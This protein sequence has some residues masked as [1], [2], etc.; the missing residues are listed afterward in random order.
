MAINLGDAEL[1]IKGD[2]SELEKGFAGMGK[3]IGVA[4]TA[5]GGTITAALGVAVSKANEFSEGIGNIAT[6]GVPNLNELKTGIMDVAQAIGVDLGDAAAA[7]Y[8]IISAGVE[9]AKAIE[10]LGASA[11]AAKAGI[12][13]LNDAVDLGTTIMNAFGMTTEDTGKI[14]DMTQAAINAGKTNIAE[15]GASVGK[16]APLMKGTGVASE[17]LFA[18]LA[19]LTTGGKSTAESVTGL[20]AIIQSLLKPTS[21]AQK[22][23]KKLGIEWDSQALASKGLSGIMTELAAATGGNVD[24]ISA[25]IP[26]VEALP[27]AL[28]LMADGG[29]ELA[30]KLDQVTNSTGE[31][32]DAFQ[33]YVDAN[34]AEK[35][36]RLKVVVEV[37]AIKIG[38]ALVPAIGALTDKLIPWLQGIGDWITA[39]PKLSAGIIKVTGALGILFFILG[40]VVILVAQLKIALLGVGTAS[41]PAA[42][43][44]TAV[45][46]AATVATA[47]VWAWVLALAA[48]GIALVKVAKSAWETQK[49]T[50]E[51][52]EKMRETNRLRQELLERAGKTEEEINA[53]SNAIADEKIERIKVELAAELGRAATTEEVMARMIAAGD[54][55]S[56]AEAAAMATN[57]AKTAAVVEGAKKEVAAGRVRIGELVMNGKT[58][59]MTISAE[60]QAAIDAEHEK[61]LAWKNSAG[62]FKATADIV[63]KT[64]AEISKTHEDVTAT[65]A[66]VWN[67]LSPKVRK[68]VAEIAGSSVEGTETIDQAWT[69]LTPELQKEFTQIIEGMMKTSP[70]ARQSPSLVEQT[71]SGLRTMGE[72]WGNFSTGLHNVLNGLLQK[73]KA[74]SPF[75]RQSPSIVDQTRMGTRFMYGIW[76]TYFGSI[77]QLTESFQRRQRM[78][79]LSVADD[80]GTATDIME[81]RWTVY[82][83]FLQKITDR[84]AENMQKVADMT[85]TA[86]GASGSSGSSGGSS[87]YGSGSSTYGGS[88][89]GMAEA[90]ASAT[91]GGNVNLNIDMSGASVRSDAD[92]ELLS[93]RLMRHTDRALQRAG[94]QIGLSTAG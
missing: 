44:I 5:I 6:L 70:L 48:A 22:M 13:S 46:G 4:M 58:F 27:T 69:K 86:T 61:V 25:L 14:F 91:V 30:N 23:A 2:P 12:G 56:A 42:A 90:F 51:M 62:Q 78:L 36:D 76:H 81:K 63:Q 47:P 40:P 87:G 65:V 55:L 7:T 35:L 80:T 15:L 49:A 83:D 9:P 92:M 18:A 72:L 85:G 68:A 66:S 77:D 21:E 82:S 60:R 94:Y 88:T 50:N 34:P 75:A 73:I 11:V 3:K 59:V 74:L 24:Q 37:L 16:V 29:A 1:K 71:G 79:L 57:K 41:V 19:Q 33:R 28:R 43:G 38:D 17:E 52:F 8:D 26:S 67:D 20:M 31:S 54:K 64:S 93:R 45:G 84:M 10:F 32:Q 89:S 39:N 53:R